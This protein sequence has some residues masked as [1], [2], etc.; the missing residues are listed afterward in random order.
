MLRC[1]MKT[2]L[3]RFQRLNPCS[4]KAHPYRGIFAETPTVETEVT[5]EL[6]TPTVETEV[7]NED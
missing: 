5:K 6:F 7:K 4:G 2:Y 1:G 3:H